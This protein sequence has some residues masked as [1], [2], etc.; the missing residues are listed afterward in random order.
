MTTSPDYFP[1]EKE[2]PADRPS[3]RARRPKRRRPVRPP[4]CADRQAARRRV[5][6]V[7]NDGGLE[8]TV[9]WHGLRLENRYDGTHETQR[10]ISIGGSF[11]YRIEFVSSFAGT[12]AGRCAATRLSVTSG[13]PPTVA[14]TSE[15]A[16]GLDFARPRPLGYRR[17]ARGN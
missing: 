6:D 9:H 5:A 3:A 16:R 10:P 4:H 17:N 7:V 12:H 2:G 8:A 13:V 15:K 1:T 14:V 11:A